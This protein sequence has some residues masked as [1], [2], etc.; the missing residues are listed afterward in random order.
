VH[1]PRRLRQE[2]GSLPGGVAA[3][4]DDDFL[5]LA[6]LPFEKRGAVIHTRVLELIEVGDVRLAIPGA[7]GH[8]HGLGRNLRAVLE[9]HDVRPAGARQARGAV[10]DDDLGAE[11]LGLVVRALGQSLTRH[12]FRKAEVILDLRTGAGLATRNIGFE[13]EH[14]ETFGRGVHRRRQPAWTGTDDHQIAHQRVIERFIET[15]FRRDLAVR[16]IAHDRIARTDDHRMSASV[17]WK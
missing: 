13:H 7:S 10:G 15:K 6:Q 12:A 8:N 4:H 1:A 17:T 11:L 9:V 16:R 14:V 5:R 2:D 3:A